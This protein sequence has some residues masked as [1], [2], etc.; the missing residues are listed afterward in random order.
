[1]T[2][3]RRVAPLLAPRVSSTAVRMGRAVLRRPRVTRNTIGSSF[4]S[5]WRETKRPGRVV[6]TATNAR[7]NELRERLGSTYMRS[8]TDREPSTTPELKTSRLTAR[9][10]LQRYTEAIV[11]ALR[12]S[13]QRF[14]RLELR[15]RPADPAPPY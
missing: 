15:S 2:A 10:A 6:P 9:S 14:G 8:L 4:Q 13:V 12:V 7:V 1:M 11:A 3:L 5:T